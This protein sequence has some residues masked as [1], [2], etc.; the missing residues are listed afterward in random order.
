MEEDKK[1]SLFVIDSSHNVVMKTNDG[2]FNT[3]A[4]FIGWLIYFSYVIIENL[5]VILVTNS[6][7]NQFWDKSQIADWSQILKHS[8][9]SPSFFSSGFSIASLRLSGN[10]PDNNDA[11]IM[12]LMIGRR[13]PLHCFKS[14]VKI[15]SRSQCFVGRE[16]I[17]FCISESESGTKLEN[18]AG[19]GL[20]MCSGM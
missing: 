5:S 7:L 19:T 10:N 8:G 6:T 17:N 2:R 14:H 1:H 4:R 20:G 18:T 9:S 3:M 11:L 12:L 15:G 13:V 16:I